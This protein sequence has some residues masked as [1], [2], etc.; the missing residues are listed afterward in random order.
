MLHSRLI[1]AF[2]PDLTSVQVR[3]YPALLLKH[4]GYKSLAYTGLR[5]G[6]LRLTRID[7]INKPA[8]RDRV[9]TLDWSP[10][11]MTYGRYRRRGCRQDGFARGECYKKSESA[12]R[13]LAWT[14]DIDCKS[15]TVF[16]AAS[17]FKAGALRSSKHKL[18]NHRG[19]RR[20][21]ELTH[22]PFTS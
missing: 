8:D 12:K 7:I 11:V 13:V 18:R 1:R 2:A 22:S 20:Q 5:S 4:S 21:T 3:L 17:I 10:R 9:V 14:S 6:F 15:H 19:S 16:V